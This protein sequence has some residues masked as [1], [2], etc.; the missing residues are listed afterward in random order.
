MYKTIKVYF[1]FVLFLL[2]TACSSNDWSYRF[3]GKSENWNVVAE[4]I[5]D[6]DNGAR[7]IGKIKHLSEEKIKLIRYEAKMTN[8][9]QLQGKIENPVF[10]DGYIIL[11]QDLPNTESA[12]KEFKNG[13]T[14]DEIKLF[15]GEY[16]VYKITWIDEQGDEH[17]ETIQ[18]KFVE[19]S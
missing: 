1:V 19:S 12:K 2:V 9:S 13:V 14:E 18:L 17:S 5:P 6:N 16:P 4:I 10:N 7:F 15:F 8:T 3:E 11:F